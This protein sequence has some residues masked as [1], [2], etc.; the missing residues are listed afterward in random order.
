MSMP[1]RDAA[2]LPLVQHATTCIAQTA[3]ADP[4]YHADM[5]PDEINDLIV[6]SIAACDSLV[7]A[8]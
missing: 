8:S 1:E 2:L 4:R 3:L 6:N 5:R 7:C